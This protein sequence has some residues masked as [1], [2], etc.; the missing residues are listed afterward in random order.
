MKQPIRWAE[1]CA[2]GAATTLRLLAGP[3]GD[4]P[5]NY[6]GGKRRFA[7]AILD[8]LGLEAK[9][10]V[11]RVVLCDAGPWGRLWKILLGPAGFDRTAVAL[12][13]F[14]TRKGRELFEALAG[15]P[16]PD[17]GPTWAAAFLLLQA[18]NSR[19]RPV[20][21]LPDG[22]WRTAGYARGDTA[23]CNC[24][25][26]GA[27]RRVLRLA[28]VPWPPDRVQVFDCDARLLDVEAL[29]ITHAYIDP[30]YAGTTGYG[31]ALPREDVLALAR[32]LQ[33]AGAV[34]AV[35]EG[36]KLAGLDDFH[37][38]DLSDYSKAGNRN[39]TFSKSRAEILHVSRPPA[40]VPAAQLG[41]DLGA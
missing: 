2:G 39:R 22:T 24:L 36:E 37:A 5:A 8:A 18:G 9:A 16:Q 34:V 1:I 35:S 11:E 23:R 13:S 31:A 15:A 7:P 14:G 21:A 29:R 28:H 17:H 19:G 26:S 25:P 3:A 30:P 33:A 32:R 27:A 4:P 40:K 41:L 10:R 38:L 12:R 6:M 20:E